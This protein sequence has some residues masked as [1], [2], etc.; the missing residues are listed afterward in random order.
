GAAQEALRALLVQEPW[1]ARI[2]AIVEVAVQE[3]RQRAR[4][5]EMEAVAMQRPQ[6]AQ[7]IRLTVRP[8]PVQRP[9]TAGAADLAAQCIAAGARLADPDDALARAGQQA[10]NRGLAHA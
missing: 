9:A 3:C 5:F 7:H 2:Q 10:R 6:F 1:K 4:R 8:D